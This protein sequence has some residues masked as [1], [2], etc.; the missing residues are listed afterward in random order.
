MIIKSAEFIKSAAATDGLL[1]SPLPQIAI[2]G[3]S[4]VGKSSFINMLSNNSKLARTSNLP[5]R[6]RLVN[7]FDFKDFILVDLPGYGYAKASKAEKDKWGDLIETYLLK[8]KNLIRVLMLV[9][10]RHLPTKDDKL[11]CKFLYFNQ[12]PF[13]IIATKSDKLNK[14]Q[15]KPCLLD[16]AG[17]LNVGIDNITA[18]SSVNKEGK[19]KVIKL[20]SEILNN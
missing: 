9:D 17:H 20:I 11:F 4:N 14:Q 1:K 6:T 2:C 19:D 16:I 10:I 5:G 8:E 3:K 15:I 13:N 12:I 18:I 7:Y